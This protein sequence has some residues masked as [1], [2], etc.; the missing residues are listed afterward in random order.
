MSV[1]SHKRIRRASS[2]SSS[3]DDDGHVIVRQK[4]D[5]LDPMSLVDVTFSRSV[6]E[7]DKKLLD[8]YKEDHVGDFYLQECVDAM[9]HCIQGLSNISTTLQGY[10]ACRQFYK[11]HRS[12]LEILWR[13]AQKNRTMDAFRRLSK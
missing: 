2:L 12:K 6:E 13:D 5:E 8:D 11:R 1:S 9:R 7:L 4:T 10:E 3:V